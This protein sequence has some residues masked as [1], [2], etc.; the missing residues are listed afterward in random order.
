MRDEVNATSKNI[1]GLVDL[2]RVNRHIEKLNMTPTRLFYGVVL[3]DV[4]KANVHDVIFIKSLL[5]DFD[6]GGLIL[7]LWEVIGD[8]CRANS[9]FR[10]IANSLVAGNAH[11]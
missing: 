8:K 10:R 6:D 3:I 1:G 5:D 7:A 9:K 11:L 4:A 2:F